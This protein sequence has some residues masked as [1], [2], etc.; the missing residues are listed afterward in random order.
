MRSAQVLFGVPSGVE[1]RNVR[2]DDAFAKHPEFLVH[3]FI[4][5]L[6]GFRRQVDPDPVPLKFFRRD[7]GRSA[8]AERVKND[9]AFI[10]AC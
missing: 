8:A 10:A 6:T 2:P 5:D 3:S 9:I 4:R 1:F 7:Q